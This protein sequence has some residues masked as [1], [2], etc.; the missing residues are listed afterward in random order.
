MD[1]APLAR[2]LGRDLA[3]VD[4]HL[5][6]EDDPYAA[7]TLAEPERVGVRPVADA[8]VEGPEL[9]LTLPPISWA[10]VRLE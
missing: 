4:S 3:L 1:L 9:R 7:N 5:L 6:H 10:A 2:E 8:V